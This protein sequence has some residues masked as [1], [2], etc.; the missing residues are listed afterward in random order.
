MGLG[1]TLIARCVVPSIAREGT[2]AN[3]AELDVRML[4][5]ARTACDV[6]L[7]MEIAPAGTVTALRELRELVAAELETR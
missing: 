2:M 6:L 1:K 5:G 4:F 7:K 3:V